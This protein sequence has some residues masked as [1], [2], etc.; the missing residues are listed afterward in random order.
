[1]IST[2]Q[3]T[4]STWSN[5]GDWN[6]RDMLHMGKGQVHTNFDWATW[7]QE[8]NLEDLGVDG[9][10]LLQWIDKNRMR[11]WIRLI[12]FRIETATWLVW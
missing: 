2:P 3:Q 9:R 8:N 6:G 12:W 1:M 5:H 10:I 4:R 11:A 7:D